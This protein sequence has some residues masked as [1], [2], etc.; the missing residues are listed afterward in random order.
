MFGKQASGKKATKCLNY[1]SERIFMRQFLH[2]ELKIAII[3]VSESVMFNI[4]GQDSRQYEVKII[5]A[6]IKDIKK[7]FRDVRK[8]TYR[9]S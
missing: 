5:T 6:D 2:F 7:I 8:F 3:I 4:M 9:A 1:C